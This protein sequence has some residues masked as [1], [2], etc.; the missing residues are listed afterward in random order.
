MKLELIVYPHDTLRKQ[1]DAVEEFN[2]QLKDGLRQMEK[3][4]LK[5][6]GLGLAAPQ[7]DWNVQCFLV[8]Y[9]EKIHTFINPQLLF[10]GENIVSYEEG[11]LSIPGIYAEVSRPKLLRIRAQNRKGDFFEIESDTF[12]ARIIL[13]EY[14]HLQGVL[15]ID[16]L[17]KNMRSHILKEYQLLQQ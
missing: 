14:D 15:F 7:V 16:H 9:E 2:N 11:C 3:I 6:K 5:K 17:P 12:F 1:V 10:V 13:H 4:L 8:K